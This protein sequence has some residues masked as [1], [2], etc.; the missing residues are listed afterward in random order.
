MS[1][2]RSDLKLRTLLDDAGRLVDGAEAPEL[3]RVTAMYLHMRR[4]RRLDERMQALQRQ[5]RIGF[6]GACTGQE[7]AP[8]AAALCLSPEDWV[9]PALRE[10]ALALT[11]GLSL[12]Q[13]LSQLFGNR[14]DLLKG[15]QM[16][17][18]HA[19]RAQNHVS[20]SSAIGTQ[21]PH[22]VGAAMAAKRLRHDSVM[23]AFLGDGATSHPDFHAALNFAGVFGAPVVFVCQNNHY[24]I[25]LPATRQTAAGSFA[26]KGSAYGVFADRVDGND[27]LVVLDAIERALTRARAGLGATL[28]ECVT[29]RVGP[30]SSSD[31][32]SRYRDDSEV[33]SWQARDPIARLAQYLR[34][35]DPALLPTLDAQ[36]GEWDAEI[37]RKLAE[38]E[39]LP[40][41]PRE[42]LFE[43]V[44]AALP[45]HLREQR[46]QLL[47]LESPP[48][49]RR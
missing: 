2:P 6:Y 22:A 19:G 45:W 44:Y 48:E 36:D 33:R 3:A 15:R 17:S 40:A 8:V 14:A 27:A 46:A 29:Y 9:F 12:G 49:A 43:D 4:V 32:P 5:G 38:I 31:D 20:W 23:L 7:A 35:V 41:P 34:H 24:A 13:Y 30:H 47:A 18:H 39:P 11:R 42:S 26:Q 25:S 21:L 1:A 10:S 28:L 37:D 16:P